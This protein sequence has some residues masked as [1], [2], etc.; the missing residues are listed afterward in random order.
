MASTKVLAKIASKWKK[1]SGLTM[2]KNYDIKTFLP[3]LDVNDVWGIGSQT[4]SYL[5]K[6]NIN[7]AQEFA[8]KSEQ[9]IKHN[10]TKPHQEVW[11]EL[12]GRSVYKVASGPRK[13]YISI[14][15]TRTFSPPSDDPKTVYAQLIKNVENAFIKSRRHELAAKKMVVYLKT[16]QFKYQGLEIKLNRPTCWTHETL[17]LVKQVFKKLFVK[18]TLYRATGAV[19][20]GLQTNQSIQLNLFENPL[21]IDK[22]QN[23][24]A[25]VDKLSAKYG[26]HTVFLGS[27][28]L[29]HTISQHQNYRGAIPEA[30]QNR[31][32]QINSRKF[33]NLPTLLGRVK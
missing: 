5:Y 18:K 10:F 13:D 27:S 3:K 6:F 31:A 12:N 4:S 28:M 23:I 7:T 24:Y 32:Q 16:N 2:I 11:Q 20:C 8:D 15:K 1:P 33:V 14:S 21:A 17:P 22:L 19:L 9:W 26:K 25:S 30:K 29:A